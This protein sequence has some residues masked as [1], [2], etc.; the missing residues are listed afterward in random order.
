MKADVA[1]AE[2]AESDGS[3][4]N[5]GIRKRWTWAAP[6]LPTSYLPDDG[7]QE[8]KESTSG[9]GTGLEGCSKTNSPDSPNRRDQAC[10]AT[11]L[12]V[13]LV[14]LGSCEPLPVSAAKSVNFIARSDHETA[15]ELADRWQDGLEIKA[16]SPAFAIKKSLSLA[17]SPR[18][19]P[20]PFA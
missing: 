17:R 13:R 5:D 14:T 18:S 6:Y 9:S 20:A 3:I 10:D 12:C 4:S 7:V 11:A 1:D 8:S 16:D 2:V 19:P 15:V